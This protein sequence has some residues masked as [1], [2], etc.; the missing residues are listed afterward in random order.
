M[1]GRWDDDQSFPSDETPVAAAAA[2]AP[3]GTSLLL[4][5][6]PSLQAPL[7]A[8]VPQVV[9]GGKEGLADAPQV[10]CGGTEG[11]ADVPQVVCGGKEGLADVPQVVCGG[12]EGLAEAQPGGV[13]RSCSE[14]LA[15]LV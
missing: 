5:S 12:R 11:V 3:P 8:D 7:L 4:V 1:A 13:G 15:G 9:C 10:V 2:V 14:L 6:D